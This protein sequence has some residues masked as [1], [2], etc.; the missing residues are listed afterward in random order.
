M[1]EWLKDKRKPA[2][3]LG[4]LGAVLFSVLRVLL[5]DADT[6]VDTGA[7][8]ASYGLIALLAV[9]VVGLLVLV[10]CRKEPRAPLDAQRTAAPA[11]AVCAA[12]AVIAVSTFL[13]LC[14]FVGQGI[15][16]APLSQIANGADRFCLWGALLCGVLGGIALIV[17]GVSAMRGRALQPWLQGLLI[18]PVL[19]LWFRLARYMLSYLSAMSMAQ[20]FYDYAMMVFQLLFMFHLM[21]FLGGVG[22]IAERWLL[23]STLGTVVCSLSNV[24]TRLFAFLD[25]NSAAFGASQLAGFADAAVGV[26]ALVMALSMWSDPPAH[27]PSALETALMGETSEVIPDEEQESV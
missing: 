22:K 12:G 15:A 11:V 4:C 1:K 21:R 24:A 9:L 5:L 8:Q 19:W 26:L 27:V 23:L 18:L 16:P 7:Y 20:T 6:D 17:Y 3:A 2:I 13:E 10:W 25:N 14:A